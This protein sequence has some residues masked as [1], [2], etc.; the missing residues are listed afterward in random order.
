MTGRGRCLL[1]GGEP[2]ADGYRGG[3]RG[4]VLDQHLSELRGQR[5]GL[6]WRYRVTGEDGGDHRGQRGAVKRRLALHRGVKR[7]AE[8][9]D[10]GRRAH[11]AAF[12]LLRGHVVRGADHGPGPGQPGRGV[13]DPGD[14]EV[15]HHDPVSAQQDVV[16]LQVAVHHPRR[17]R[18]G[19]GVGDLRADQRD[20]LPGQPPARGDLGRERARRGR[21]P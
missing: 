9:P 3:A 11:V 1:A 2:L 13:D 10:V 14:A 8:R 15:G 19:Q 18:A 21:T 5:A 7:G 20:P 16:R 12:K 4:G 6:H 17:V